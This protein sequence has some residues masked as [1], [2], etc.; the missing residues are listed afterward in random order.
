M[1]YLRILSKVRREAAVAIEAAVLAKSVLDV[2]GKDSAQ[3]LC[4]LQRQRT[5]IQEGCA[6]RVWAEWSDKTDAWIVG[7]AL[8]RGLVSSALAV[9]IERCL[10]RRH[11][12]Y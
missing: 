8:E 5:V 3:R 12:T 1:Y 10:L 11:S 6:P 7:D 2:V 4:P 9:L